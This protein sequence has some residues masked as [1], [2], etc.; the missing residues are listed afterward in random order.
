MYNFTKNHNDR[1]ISF[2]PTEKNVSIQDYKYL[3]SEE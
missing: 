3:L 2:A 1:L